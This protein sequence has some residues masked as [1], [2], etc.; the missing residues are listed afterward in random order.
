MQ[1]STI[2]NLARALNVPLS[3]VLQAIESAGLKK[4]PA[5]E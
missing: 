4:E 3:D 5:S 1:Y 2:K